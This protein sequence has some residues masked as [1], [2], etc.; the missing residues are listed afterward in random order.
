MVVGYNGLYFKVSWVHSISSRKLTFSWYGMPEKV[1]SV[2]D[3]QFSSTDFVKFSEEYDFEQNISS[4]R[5]PQSNNL[6]EWTVQTMIFQ[7]AKDGNVNPN[8]GIL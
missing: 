7:K 3:P 8:L 6:A 1:V 2:N 4:P 5:Y